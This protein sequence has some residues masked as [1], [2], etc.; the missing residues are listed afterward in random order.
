MQSRLLVTTASVTRG[1]SLL[2]IGAVLAFLMS[3]PVHA[4]DLSVEPSAQSVPA[5]ST[6]GVDIQIAGLGNGIPPSLGAFDFDLTFDPSVLTFDSLIFGDP[7]LGDLLGPVV[8]STTGSSL[9]S[10]AGS[11]NLFAVSLDTPADLDAIQPDKFILAS[12]RFSATGA[13]S[14]G[15]DL[16]SIIL[17][18]AL[19]DPLIP[20]TVRGASVTVVHAVPEGSLDG[21]GLFLLIFTVAGTRWLQRQQAAGT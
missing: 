6:V 19:G 20:D 8:G 18:D 5:G 15:L 1:S 9:D 12:V 3:S 2:S 21:A 11:L 7:G 14:S 17:G 16:S 13:G 4:V 10:L